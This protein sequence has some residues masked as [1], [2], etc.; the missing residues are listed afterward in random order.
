MKTVTVSLKDEYGTFGGRLDCLSLDD[1]YPRGGVEWKRPAVV[2]VPGGAYSS[3]S[4]REGEGVA[5]RFLAQGFQAAVLTYSVVGEGAKYPDQLIELGCA[6]DYMRKHA[7]ELYVNPDEIFVVGFSAG[8]HLTANLAVEYAV[9]SQKAGFSV[10]CKPTAVGLCYPVITNKTSYGGT[11]NNLLNGYA[12]GEKAELLKTLNLDEAVTEQTAPSFIW[13]TATDELVPA[14][15]SLRFATALA[16]KGVAYELHVY[17]KGGHGLSTGDS[18]VSPAC[19]E[20]R[21]KQWVA[22]CVAFFRNFTEEKF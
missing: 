2:V 4:K 14:V 18:E 5:A 6:I 15:N 3:V 7:K 9:V 16:E 21:L 1:T 17:P 20:P 12:E 11:H 13:T 10:D 8:G 22:D 19:P